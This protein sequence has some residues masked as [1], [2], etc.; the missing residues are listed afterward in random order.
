MIV[1][2]ILVYHNILVLYVCMF[3]MF[4][5]I[6][7]FLVKVTS[8]FSWFRYCIF[9][10]YCNFAWFLNGNFLIL[11]HEFH[12]VFRFILFVSYFHCQFLSFQ[13]LFNRYFFDIFDFE[14]S[15]F[16]NDNFGA[17]CFCVL[18]PYLNGCQAFSWSRLTMSWKLLHRSVAFDHVIINCGF[19]LLV[20]ICM[21]FLVMSIV[22]SILFFAVDIFNYFGVGCFFQIDSLFNYVEFFF[23][24][25][26]YCLSLHWMW[27]F[28]WQNY[29]LVSHWK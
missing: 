26:V 9:G 7:N 4:C 3:I 21:M 17:N 23:C 22:C 6:N 11:Q 28:D 10:A 16:N 13:P 25:I 14:S 18:I 2:V 12:H 19:V 15:F 29:Q 5:A 24:I 27:S 8:C 1:L 20:K